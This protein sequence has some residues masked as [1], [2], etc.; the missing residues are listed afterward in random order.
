MKYQAEP[1]YK[2]LTQK[3]NF[4]G[5]TCLQM[6]LFRRGIWMSQEMI[7]YSIGVNIDKKDKELYVLPFNALNS[8]DPRVGLTFDGFLGEKVK[9]F[10][11]D[12][13]LKIEGH[14]IS[15]IGDVKKFIISNILKK[16]DVIINFSWEP[17]DGRKNAG[18]YVLVAD[19]NDQDE[20]FT[21]CDPSGNKKS[22]WTASLENFIEA[23]QKKWDKKERGFLV[24]SDL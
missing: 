22:F 10:L 20:I 15:S 17:F 7:A 14:R 13:G 4:C 18:H 16:N 12:N 6:A 3:K 5:P 24:I 23:M 2:H 21:V 9:K 8:A 19:F 1:K 11:A